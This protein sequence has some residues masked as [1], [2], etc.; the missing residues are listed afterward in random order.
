MAKRFDEEDGVWRTVGGRRIFIKQ[1]QSL[2]EA[3]KESGKFKTDR[4]SKFKKKEE[5]EMQEYVE[6]NKMDEKTRDHHLQKAMGRD[7][8]N[9]KD[10]DDYLKIPEKE[11][12]QAYADG[13]DW[14]TLVDEKRKEQKTLNKKLTD[15]DISYVSSTTNS[16]NDS[17]G[18]GF[19]EMLNT[20]DEEG[21]KVKNVSIGNAGK[22]KASIEFENGAKVDFYDLKN[23][24]ATINNASTDDL[25]KIE[26]VVDTYRTSSKE[27]ISYDF[28]NGK[29]INNRENK[30][31]DVNR[32]LLD[33]DN[34]GDI[35]KAISNIENEKIK[36]YLKK[37]A[38]ELKENENNPWT[39]AEYLRKHYIFY[40]EDAEK[41]KK[42]ALGRGLEDV[43]DKNKLTEQEERALKNNLFEKQV[44]EMY[45][46]FHGKTDKQVAEEIAKERGER[47]LT[48]KEQ[49]EREVAFMKNL[50]K[51]VETSKDSTKRLGRGVKDM[52]ENNKTSKTYT[53]SDLKQGMP[54]TIDYGNGIKKTAIFLGKD[55]QGHNQF[56]D[57]SGITGTFAFSDKFINDRKNIRSNEDDDEFMRL[58]NKLRKG[59]K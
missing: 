13:K 35:D 44:D 3:M 12:A 51:E 19:N 27:D 33:A 39:S 59:K 47:I 25:K 26:K 17:Y 30:K 48:D 9:K 7:D 54:Y 15:E 18:Y 45:N 1:G 8:V 53:S 20:A 14:K 56:Y 4:S 58:Y 22:N 40:K 57:G 28:N 5:D 46:R 21:L 24:K 10:L 50:E 36:G 6:K 2:S 41:S 55:D 49:K 38:K 42:K 16:M 43:V 37:E 23:G 34:W 52:I 11:R 31:Q 29:W 32:Q